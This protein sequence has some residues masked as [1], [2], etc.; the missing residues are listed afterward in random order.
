MRFYKKTTLGTDKK[1]SLIDDV[2]LNNKT[3]EYNEIR[4]FGLL[5]G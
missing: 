4:S 1:W 5:T 2:G 3:L